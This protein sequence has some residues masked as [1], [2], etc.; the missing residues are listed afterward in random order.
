MALSLAWIVLLGM[1][2]HSVFRKIGLPGLL[3]LLLLGVLGGP[4]GFNFIDEQVIEISA[5]LRKVAL[6]VILLRAGLGIKRETLNQVGVNALKLSFIPCVMEGM[7]I[8]AAAYYFFHYSFLEAGMLGFIIA[9]VSPAVIV[10]SMLRFIE[11]GKGEKKGIPTM[12]LAGASLDDV[13]AITFLTAFIGIYG[14]SQVA[15]WQQFLSIPIAIITGLILGLAV[16]MI[17]IMFF[18]RLD[19][20]N[21]KKTLMLVGAGILMTG[22]EDALQSLLPVAS[23]IGIMFVGFILLERKPDV[24]SALSSKMNKV[25]VLAEIILFTMVGAVV[26]IPL[27]LE[28]GLT[29]MILIGLGL[30]A[31]SIGV[32]F[33]LS[34]KLFSARERLFCVVA[35]TPKATV[36]AAVGALPL[37]AG[38][39]MGEEILA[40]AVLAIVLT[41]PVGAWLIQW[42]GESLLEGKQ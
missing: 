27:A 22:I 29:G 34:G 24:A 42:G 15:L 32:F 25:W 16:A 2:F 36:Q 9:A 5:D 37:A 8:M 30:A 11:T 31:R 21:T 26:N 40:F 12:I 13:V 10:P 33:S 23:L 20:R 38:A 14:G 41:A 7:A 1:L 28:A 35:Y 19:I 3:G 6:I 17:L 39:P 18:N 4:Y